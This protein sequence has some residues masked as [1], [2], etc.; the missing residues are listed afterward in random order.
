VVDWRLRGD[1]AR[2]LSITMEAG[3]CL[4]A[5]EEAVARHG[6]RTFFDTDQDS[7][8]GL[9]PGIISQEFTGVLLK[10]GTAISMGGTGAWRDNVFVRR[11]W[12]SIK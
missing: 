5:L 9:D 10:A 6:R 8:P 4:E 3:F 1:L 11:L 2:R 12:R 7:L